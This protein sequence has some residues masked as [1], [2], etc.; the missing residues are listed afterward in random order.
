MKLKSKTNVKQTKPKNMSRSNPTEDSK[1]INPAVKFYEWSGS[2]GKLKYYDKE[3]KKS[4]LLDL[5]F[6]FLPLRRCVAV[7]GY[8]GDTESSYWSNEVK[9]TRTEVLV[10]QSATG[11]GDKR[12]I[13]TEAVG[14]YKDIKDKIKGMGVKYVE[15]LYIASYDAKGKLELCNIQIKG[16]MLRPWGDLAKANNIWTSAIK[17]DSFVENKKGGIKFRVPVLKVISKIKPET[18]D[19]A[20]ELDKDIE[21]YLDAY[22]AKNAEAAKTASSE[23]VLHQEEKPVAK[24]QPIVLDVQE[25]SVDDIISEYEDDDVPF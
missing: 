23:E 8:N 19:A 4:V 14:L 6:T 7:K 20:I 18:N 21:A 22:F 2:E 24:R 17:I 12:K 15:S 13:R 9:D 5:P 1:A 3:T 16:S 10:V 25:D 11:T